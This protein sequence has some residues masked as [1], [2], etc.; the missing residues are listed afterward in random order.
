MSIN[1]YIINHQGFDWPKLLENWHWLL[2]ERFVIWIVN[3]F[4]DLFIV[5]DD[6]TVQM[7]DVGAGALTQ[8]AQNREDFGLKLDQGDNAKGWLLIPLVDR[9]VA[10]EMTLTAGQ[11]YGFRLPPVL[12]GKYD[13]ENVAVLSI[14]DYLRG[15]G[16]IHQQIKDVPDGGQIILKMPNEGKTD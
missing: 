5:L 1:D 4:G 10:A 6:D 8:V 13:L 14:D 2:P 12:G 3:R 9:L 7:L 16:S 15:Y 11:C